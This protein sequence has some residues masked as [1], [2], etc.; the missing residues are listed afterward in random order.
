MD[1]E[2]SS[3]HCGLN[4]SNKNQQSP[5]DVHKLARPWFIWWWL[6][7]VGSQFYHPTLR[8]TFECDP[9]SVSGAVAVDTDSDTGS[10]TTSDPDIDTDTRNYCLESQTGSLC[11]IRLIHYMCTQTGPLCVLRLVHHVFIMCSSCV[12]KLVQHVSSDWFIICVLRLVHY[13]LC[14]HCVF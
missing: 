6:E 2:H 4:S 3:R 13:V 1:N 10:L 14:P 7:C 12:L 8:R 5:S 9:D 11:V